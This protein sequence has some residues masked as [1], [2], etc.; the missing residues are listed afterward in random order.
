M[1]LEFDINP[2]QIEEEI[3]DLLKRGRESREAYPNLDEI[4]TRIEN[5]MIT[6]KPDQSK[7]P[8][9]FEKK[10]RKGFSFII[11]SIIGV[12]ILF[13]LIILAI[14]GGFR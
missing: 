8:D 1:K 11:A 2:K 4:L 13:I 10:K 12:I 6:I 7:V 14:K 9:F 3:K 5:K